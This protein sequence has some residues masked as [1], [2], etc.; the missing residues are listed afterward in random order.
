MA[1]VPRSGGNALSHDL[2][3]FHSNVLPFR[4]LLMWNPLL[5]LCEAA[6]SQ[7]WSKFKHCGSRCARCCQRHAYLIFQ[8]PDHCEK[9]F[10]AKVIRGWLCFSTQTRQPRWRASPW[11]LGSASHPCTFLSQGLN[12]VNLIPHG[13]CPSPWEWDSSVNLVTRVLSLRLPRPTRPA[14]T[15]QGSPGHTGTHLQSSFPL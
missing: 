7:P 14:Q 5:S 13:S 3:S 11:E 10:L 8:F 1:S 12:C 15:Q 9:R 4:F 2:I 6:G